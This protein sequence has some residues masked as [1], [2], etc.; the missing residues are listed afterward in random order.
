M[1]DPAPVTYQMWRDVCTRLDNVTA[2][3]ATLEAKLAAVPKIEA[4]PPVEKPPT[5]A[6]K[7]SIFGR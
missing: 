5:A 6:K 7:P 4:V 3:V 1:P 2:R